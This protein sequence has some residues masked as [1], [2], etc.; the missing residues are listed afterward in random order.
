MGEQKPKK[1]QK[2][3]SSSS[4]QETDKIS[5]LPEHIRGRI[6]CYLPIQDAIRTTILSKEWRNVFKSLFHLSFDQT[7]FENK[8]LNSEDFKIFVDQTLKLRDDSNVQQFNLSSRVDE[9]TAPHIHEWISYAVN[10]NV[11]E[12][13]LHIFAGTFEKLPGCLFTS[14]NLKVLRL[15]GLGFR[16]PT[17]VKFSLLKT[18]NLR[19]VMFYGDEPLNAL[20]S[21]CPVIEN[22]TIAS[23]TWDSQAFINI[24][25]PSLKSLILSIVCRTHAIKIA[26]ANLRYIRYNGFPPD[27]SSTT[28]TSLYDARFRFSR[29]YPCSTNTTNLSVQ[30]YNVSRILNGLHNVGKLWLEHLYIEYL[31]R[32][33]DFFASPLTSCASLT[34]LKLDMYSTDNHVSVIKFLLKSCPNLQTLSICVQEKSTQTLEMLSMEGYFPVQELST[35]ECILKHL[36]TVE[37]S[38]YEGSESEL[39]LMTFLRMN[40]NVLKDINIISYSE[41]F[42]EDVAT[43]KPKD[44]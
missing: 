41:Q 23:C 28:L 11:Q 32:V 43:R 20:I 1:N 8:K 9:F 18:I 15:N 39:D 24:S 35:D 2:T 31:S 44:Y 6:L 27:I 21:N 7:Y 3:S 13:D 22:I 17:L 40:A 29:L 4:D 10:H 16:L 36:M 30:A 37:I 5:K 25:F 33:K 42:K 19:R 14:P 38:S 34:D 26:A 12:L